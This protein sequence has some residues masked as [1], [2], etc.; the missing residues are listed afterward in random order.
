FGFAI[1]MMI[2]AAIHP[3]F[4]PQSLLV[5]VGAIVAILLFY[6]YGRWVSRGD[7]GFISKKIEASLSV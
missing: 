1:Y 6:G 3:E 4:Q 7:K 2:A 5:P